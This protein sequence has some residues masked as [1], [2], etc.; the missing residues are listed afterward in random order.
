MDNSDAKISFLRHPAGN[1][2]IYNNAEAINTHL[3]K[4]S[5][6]H[7][8]TSV[9]DSEI[10]SS[11]IIN[12]TVSRSLISNCYVSNSYL[13]SIMAENSIF[14]CELVSTKSKIINSHVLNKSR[15]LG[16]ARLSNVR[17]KRLTVFNS[18]ILQDWSEEVF[19][20]Q[21]G[22]VG[23][24]TWKSPPRILRLKNMTITESISG[25]AFVG[26]RHRKISEWLAYGERIGIVF[27]VE[28]NQIEKIRSFLCS[29]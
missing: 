28:K 19:D 14:G 4:S 7:G 8:N 22:Y 20:G 10:F 5:S 1:G 24:G 29:L 23:F 21:N 13:C 26:C 2:K 27:G 6:L 3:D 17:F 9:F 12:S 25:Y 16:S 18:A 11:K 15:V